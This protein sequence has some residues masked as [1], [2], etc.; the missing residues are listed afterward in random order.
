MRQQVVATLL[1][2]A[3]LAGCGSDGNDDRVG[4][5]PDPGDTRST[6]AV[7]ETA[8]TVNR[9]GFDVHIQLLKANENTVTSPVSLASLLGMLAAGADGAASADLNAR[10]GLTSSTDTRIGG[11]MAAL[12]ATS[13]VTLD[14]ANSIWTNDGVKLLAPYQT[15]VHDTYRAEATSVPLGTPRGADAIDAWVK[16]ATNDKID[17]MADALGLPDPDAV[18]VLLNAGYFKGTWTTEFDPANT[19]PMPFSL[20]DGSKLDVPMM[21]LAGEKDPWETASSATFSLL[22]LP[23]GRDGRFAMELL[24]PSDVVDIADFMKRLDF[25][26]WQATRSRLSPGAVAVSLPRFTTKWQSDLNE[27]LTP[28]P[29]EVDRPFAFA[30]TDRTTGATLFLGAINDPTR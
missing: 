16:R 17:K 20:A 9:I 18:T 10:L 12:G 19:R 11:L 26:E 22:R 21:S 1:V 28:V 4:V 6:Q 14:V 2:G 27:S 8:M 25:D 13:D 30:I 3:V 23:S 29:F 15:F 24:V 5:D 7:R